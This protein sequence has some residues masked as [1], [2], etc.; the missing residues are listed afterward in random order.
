[1]DAPDPS[2][3][4]FLRLGAAAAAALG[5]G[6]LPALPQEKPAATPA[7]EPPEP[8]LTALEKF[9]DVSRGTPLPHQI[10]PEKRT[11][12]GLTRETWSLEVVSDKDHPA[13]L[14]TPLTKE[15]GTALN[16][17]GLMAL[18]RKRTVSFLKVMT[19]SNIGRPLGMG[20]WEG[21]PLRDV[22]WLASPQE[23]LRRV[24][25]YGYHNDDPK[26]MFRSS[27]PI[28]RVLEDPPGVPPVILC[29]KLN[30]QYLTPERGAPVRVVVPEAYGF[31]SVKWL[32]HVVLT[33]LFYANDTYGEGNNDVDSPLKTF[34]R[35]IA[36][37]KEAKAGEA[38]LVNGL[39]QV[40]ISGLS[41]VQ[42][43]IAPAA[44]PWPADDPYFTKAPWKDADILPA[45]AAWGGGLP[46]DKLPSPPFQFDAAT[47]RPR[48]WPMPLTKAHWAIRYPGL[49]AGSYTLRCRTVDG[50]GEAQPMP[51]PFDK[52]G[53]AGIEEKPL[54]VK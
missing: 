10:S 46:E 29:T 41:R 50:N 40:G 35:T 44:Q 17:D 26:Q 3:R 11:Q 21:V 53:R 5:A 51:R 39:A 18:A 32:T 6:P 28:G 1:M 13:D 52:S 54:V 4:S 14:K 23:N 49:P 47:G 42:V 16:W 19:C 20:L 38:I 48:Q 30:G 24:F 36:V 34:A 43:W 22:I 12:V 2:R 27:L 15:K 37:P 25:Y 31:K 7:P 33:N 9:R 45:P 8:Y